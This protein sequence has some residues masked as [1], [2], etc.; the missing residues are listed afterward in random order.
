MKSIKWLQYITLIFS[1]MIILTGIGCFFFLPDRTE[2]YISIVG[3]IIPF[4]VPQII[5][6]FGGDPLKG[7]IQNWKLQIE[8][9]KI[10]QELEVREN[11]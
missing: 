3:A 11:E 6:A 7:A 2:N 5:A 10:N 1:V 4:F 8:N 9:G